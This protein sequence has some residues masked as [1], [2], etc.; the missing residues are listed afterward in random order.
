MCKI[1]TVI[2]AVCTASQFQCGD[3]I[4]IDLTRRCDRRVDCDD[5]SDEL[6][7]RKF[8]FVRF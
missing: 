6:A 3:G 7:C 1:V 8:F 2:F 5:R 4:C